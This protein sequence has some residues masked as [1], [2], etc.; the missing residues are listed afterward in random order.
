MGPKSIAIRLSL[1]QCRLIEGMSDQPE[2][3]GCVEVVA[4]R[5]TRASKNGTRPALVTA[6]KTVDGIPAF[7]LNAMGLRVQQAILELK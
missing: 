5:L 2:I 1:G 4:R 6:S 7:Q 3:L